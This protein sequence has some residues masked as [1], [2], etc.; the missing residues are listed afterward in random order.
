MKQHILPECYLK[1]W[2][3]P[4]TPAGHEPYIWL[5]SKSGDAKRKRAPKKSFTQ[6]DK[7]TITVP[8]GERSNVIES[9]LSVIE[10]RF[11]QIRRR[12]VRTETLCDDDWSWLRIFAAT[13]YLRTGIIGNSWRSFQEQIHKRVLLL[14]KTHGLALGTSVE[15]ERHLAEH[16]GRLLAVGINSMLEMH[17]RFPMRIFVSTDELGFIASDSPYPGYVPLTPH[18]MMVFK[19]DLEKIPNYIDVDQG[20]VDGCNALARF[21]CEKEFVSWKGEIRNEWFV[22]PNVV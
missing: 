6:T 3:D 17:S 8:S 11:A 9:S 2:C 13:L 14:E 21:Q 15:T 10:D 4:R 7:Y 19:P 16:S 12:I 1:A 5:I 18:H 22:D 20:F